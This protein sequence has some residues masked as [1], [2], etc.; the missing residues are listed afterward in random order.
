MKGFNKTIFIIST[1]LLLG[2]TFFGGLGA[3][4]EED[5]TI[6]NSSSLIW[7]AKMFNILRFPTHTLFWDLFSLNGYIYILGL[8]L[9]CLLYG[10]IFERIIYYFKRSA[11]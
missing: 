9:N 4:A 3:F 1:L 2:L 6:D 8:L 11:K 5:G 10:L 7:L